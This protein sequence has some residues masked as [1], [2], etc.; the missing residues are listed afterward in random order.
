MLQRSSLIAHH[1][2]LSHPQYNWLGTIF[3]LS[4]LFFEFPQ[5]LALQRF[6]VAKWM[7]C[8]PPSLPSIALDWR[9]A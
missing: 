1:S 5:N 2:N 9:C 6:P 8:L 3:Y 7:R 4:Y